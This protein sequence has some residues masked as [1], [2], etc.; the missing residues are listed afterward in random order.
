MSPALK[1]MINNAEIVCFKGR[2][3][4]RPRARP[5]EIILAY[6]YLKRLWIRRG[7]GEGEGE[8]YLVAPVAE[9]RL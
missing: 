7:D 8:D 4:I 5:E 9:V 6:F 3:F 2:M 1:K